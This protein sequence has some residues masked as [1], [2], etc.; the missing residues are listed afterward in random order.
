[1]AP[2]RL[3]RRVAVASYRSKQASAR[4]PAGVLSEVSKPRWASDVRTGA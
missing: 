2:S 3:R 4:R 1:M